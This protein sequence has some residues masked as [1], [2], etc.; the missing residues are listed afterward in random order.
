M[1]R[2]GSLF[3]GIG[4]IE[5]GLE[6]TGYFKTEWFV[7]KELYAR[8]ILRKRF[9]KTIIYGDIEK[10]DFRT[11]P[12]ID[13]LTGG[14]PCQDIS[15]AGKRVGI[16]GSRSSLWRYYCEAIRILRPKYAI[17]ENVS[18][19]TRKG[20]NIV[21]RDIAK[22]GYD[23]EWH[24]LS[25]S[26]IGALHKRERI[27][28]VAYPNSSGEMVKGQDCDNKE[29]N[30]EKKIQ[31]WQDIIFRIESASS[32]VSN[33]NKQRQQRRKQIQVRQALLRREEP[34]WATEPKLG[35]VVDGI[36][37]RVDRIRC[38]GNAVVPQCTEI[39]GEAIKEKE[40][41]NRSS[42]HR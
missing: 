10:I 41:G 7:E 9:P 4:G 39:I 27:F 14:F 32:D 30:S 5:I 21:L 29:R 3:S 36:S 37:N 15:V 31:E 6:R 12:S 19:L 40:G 25:A 24:C 16:S 23:A 34:T 13:I 22:I 38:L 8:E 35:R 20:L 17:I 2:V 18:A 33:S 1:F 26:S 28:I 11:V 42:S